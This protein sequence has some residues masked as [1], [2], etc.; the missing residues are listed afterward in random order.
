[1]DL[2]SSPLPIGSDP[3]LP[4]FHAVGEYV[5]ETE[6][7]PYLRSSVSNHYPGHIADY[8]D[9]LF[10]DPNPWI[11]NL[12]PMLGVSV[13]TGV[14]IG[15][16]KGASKRGSQF[17]AENAHR[18]P[19]RVKAWYYYKRVSAAEREFF[20]FW[21]LGFVGRGGERKGRERGRR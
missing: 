9:S 11:D 16:W 1:M 8:W 18:K 7:E 14:V 19:R 13:V 21:V 20:F 15:F 12:T 10:P 4:P 17:T 5:P 2:K 6:Y 3:S